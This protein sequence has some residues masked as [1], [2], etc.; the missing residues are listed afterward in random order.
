MNRKI[1]EILSNVP[2]SLATPIVSEKTDMTLLNE[3]SVLRQ[4]YQAL[5]EALR[6][7]GEVIEESQE[8]AIAPL[9]DAVKQLGTIQE[10]AEGELEELKK[11]VE[12]LEKDQA[13]LVDAFQDLL[14]VY[15]A[16]I[17]ADRAAEEDLRATIEE[18]LDLETAVEEEEGVSD[19]VVEFGNAVVD[20]LED[21]YSKVKDISD[22]IRSQF[23]DTKKIME[24]GE[25]EIETEE[26]KEE[27]EK[28][29]EADKEA[30]DVLADKFKKLQKQLREKGEKEEEGEKE[31]YEDKE[32]P[33]SEKAD[34]EKETDKKEDEDKEEKAKEE[35]PPA[36][37][38]QTQA[39]VPEE[40]KQK[41]ISETEEEEEDKTGIG[42]LID[43]A[44]KAK[45]VKKTPQ[46]PQGAEA[47]KVETSGAVEEK[48]FRT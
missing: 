45:Q 3:I 43:L 48:P 33:E 36:P 7:M 38:P 10:S 19:E 8:Q 32:K 23:I 6:Q 34:K 44:R 24:A 13:D 47:S 37:A 25:T 14:D 12:E 18:A 29:E 11:R 4:N 15:E 28:G 41:P 5:R 40:T 46:L 39:P 9:T 35:V 17:E 1:S 42:K 31:E 27:E 21:I 26:K 20:A 16:K 2:I 30:I 22:A